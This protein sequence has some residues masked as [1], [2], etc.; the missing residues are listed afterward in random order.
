MRHKTSKKT[1]K[2]RIIPLTTAVVRLLKSI[3][4]RDG[5]QGAV[6]KTTHGG[7]WA[8]NS[9][10]QKIKRLRKRCGVP[11]EASL[12]GLRHRFG[13][14]AVLQGV[15]LKTLAD[16]M[17]HSRVQTTEHYLHTAEEYDHL[18]QAMARV[19]GPRRRGQG[20]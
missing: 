7:P 5:T 3:A 1:R 8:R 9:L 19:S 14:R 12:Y 15:D 11:E 16:L 20:A 2:P 4:R 10:S 13:T 18:R 6:F 17:G